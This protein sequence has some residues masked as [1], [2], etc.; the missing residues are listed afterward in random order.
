MQK[1]Y[2]VLLS[3]AV[4]FSAMAQKHA[5]HAAAATEK[6]K[7]S[8]EVGAP[9]P[10][11]VSQNRAPFDVIWSEDFGSATGVG[12]I[13]FGWTQAGVNQVWKKT[14]T[15][16]TGCFATTTYSLTS[17]TAANGVLIYDADSLNKA[18][19]ADCTGATYGPLAGELI[20]P[21]IDLT[22]EPNVRLEFEQLFRLCCSPTTTFLTVSVSGNGGASWTDYSAKGLTGINSY[23]PNGEKIS[24]NIST[25]AG[26]SNNVKIKF[27]FDSGLGTYFWQI[28][29]LRIIEGPV[30]DVKLENVYTDFSY[31]DGGYYTQTP[32]GQVA[33]ITF[34]GAIYNNGFAAQTGAD[35]DVDITGAATYSQ[36]SNTLATFPLYARDT[37][38]VTTPFN[39]SAVGAYTA[40]YTLRQTETD[41]LSADNVMT[42]TFKVSDTVY[43]RDNGAIGA[44]LTSSLS[45]SDYVGGDVDGSLIGT[46]YE[47]P[48]NGVITTASVYIASSAQLG[49][50]FDFVLYNIDASGNFVE[51]ASSDIYAVS[52]A[53]DRN[54]W[55]TMPMQSGIWPVTAGESYIIAVRQ[56]VGSGS[57]D[58][59]ILNDL[60]LENVQPKFT[61][62]V[63]AGGTGTWGW[64][65]KA[66]FLHLN[67]EALNAGVEE[68][69]QNTVLMQNIPN[70][71]TE[72][73]AINFE[74][75][76][77]SRVSLSVCDVAGKLVKTIDAGELPNGMHTITL[78]T[79]GLDAG[80]YFYTLSSGNENATKKLT[81]MKN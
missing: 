32:A 4:S 12:T 50:S 41:E 25:V 45:P 24:I 66:P 70:P 19:T 80:V 35:M 55:V 6:M 16:S 60:T 64:I 58:L 68:L 26:G 72:S 81:V 52:A 76:H 57:F 21:T 42:R 69:G 34:R 44:G 11:S 62:F 78:E 3:A 39:P 51:V 7:R 74:L 29:D 1:I 30:N 53:G 63:D 49:T 17:T 46:L 36:T 61:T 10:A 40:T 23:S 33:P 2:L 79:A 20:S 59:D 73:T 43:A 31:E 54:K 37:L 48:A 67:L 18:L 8:E 77:S 14:F 15:G 5:I 9:L 13:P 22:G 56:Y 27:K 28:D 75:K 71:A 38:T 47:F 65:Q